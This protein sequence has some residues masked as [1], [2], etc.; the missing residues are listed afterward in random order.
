MDYLPEKAGVLVRALRVYQWTKN[1]LVVAALIFARQLGEPEQVLRSLGAFI[2]FCMAA[3]ATY[4]FNDL[5][6]MEKDRAHPEKRLRPLPSGQMRPE[7]AAMLSGALLLGAMA[8]AWAVRPMFLLALLFYLALTISYSL[9]LKHY[10]IIDVLAIAL[11]FVTRALAGAI[12]LDVK[13]SNWLVV[14]T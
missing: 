7:T 12:A 4:L 10:L 13:F 3:S 9:A 14:C 5:I 2:A 11:G 1:L 8:L 6:D